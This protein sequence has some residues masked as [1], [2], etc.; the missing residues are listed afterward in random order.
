MQKLKL[1]T[2]TLCLLSACKAMKSGQSSDTKI[3]GGAE[4]YETFP[5]TV[6]LLIARQNGSLGSCTGTVVS[7]RLVLTAAHCFL[8]G[9]APAAKIM[10]FDKTPPGGIDAILETSTSTTE[11][12]TMPGYDPKLT[13]TESINSDV[14]F[15]I[16]APKT[17]EN[18][19]RA[20]L[21]S[22][23]AR[24]DQ[25]VYMVGYG[26]TDYVGSS[27]NPE[28]KRFVGTNLIVSIEREYANAITI[29]S[30]KIGIDSAGTGPGDS[31]GSLYNEAGEIIGIT[32]AG[33]VAV[34][35]GMERSNTVVS[36][37]NPGQSYYVNIHDP[38]V[39]AFIAAVMRNPAKGS[40]QDIRP[41][42]LPKRE[43]EYSPR[44][45]Q[46]ESIP[47]KDP[48]TKTSSTTSTQPETPSS[49]LPAAGT[50]GSNLAPNGK[51]YCSNN[52]GYGF[53][54]LFDCGEGLVCAKDDGVTY[55]DDTICVSAPR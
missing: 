28:L 38:G 13:W 37:D 54:D 36:A 44:P 45:A 10:V 3:I 43:E 8:K 18:H 16:F 2:A 26:N 6:G 20:T 11:Y 55:S 24:V 9:E 25:Q 12:V 5:A 47:A 7:N 29:K 22:A 40:G 19:A 33:G 35:K 1:F 23:P 32:K 52:N 17:F 27:S 50:N 48:A 30:Y 49:S 15:A 14:A 41:T 34:P 53:G 21:S 4:D 39:A 31:G 46:P 42:A 51:P